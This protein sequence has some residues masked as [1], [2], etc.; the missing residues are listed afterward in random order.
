M[1]YKSEVKE[2]SG[3]TA[4]PQ[5]REREESTERASELGENGKIEKTKFGSNNHFVFKIS[6]K[7]GILKGEH[8][9]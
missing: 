7:R 2:D 6:T 3:Y 4:T 9:F 5:E 8:E 1:L